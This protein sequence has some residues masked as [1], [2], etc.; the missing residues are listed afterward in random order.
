MV[1]QCCFKGI[2]RK[3]SRS[4]KKFQDCSNKM[5]SFMVVSRKIEECVKRVFSGFQGYLKDV[6]REFQG[7]FK[8]V[9]R[10]FQGCSKRDFRILQGNVK[11]VSRK[12]Q[13]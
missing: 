7:S 8:F 13:G 11:G 12:S 5:S 10:K 6:Q 4:F 3:F 1:L 9:T 2:L